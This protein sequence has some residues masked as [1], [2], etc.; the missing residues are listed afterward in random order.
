MLGP[1]LFVFRK[2]RNLLICY[3]I[4]RPPHICNRT[5]KSIMLGGVEAVEA[6]INSRTSVLRHHLSWKEKPGFEKPLKLASPA[7]KHSRLDVL[8]KLVRMYAQP[9]HA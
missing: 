5:G 6:N 8:R 7:L 2:W 3:G 4:F 9:F 1:K